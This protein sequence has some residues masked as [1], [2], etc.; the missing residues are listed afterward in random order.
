[1]GI[2]DRGLGIGEGGAPSG[3]LGAPTPPR[4][5]GLGAKG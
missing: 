4:E 5:W 2:G 3:E 1:L